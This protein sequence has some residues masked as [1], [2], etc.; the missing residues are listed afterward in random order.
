MFVKKPK[1]PREVLEEREKALVR[2]YFEQRPCGVV[3]DVG[4]NEPVSAFSQSWHLEEKLG[5]KAVLVEPNPVLAAR[6]RSARPNALTFECACCATEADLT[7]YIPVKEDGGEI[8]SH[9]AIGKNLDSHSYAK[10][11]EVTVRGRPLDHLLE[12]AGV[13]SID[14]L[15]IDVEGAELEV[16]KGFDIGKYRP[17]LILLE[18]KHL[19]LNK[20]RYLTRHGYRLCKRTGLNCW[21]VPQ[22]AR[23]PPQS[24]REKARIF[25]R[26]YLS[27]WWKKLRYALRTER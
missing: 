26:L 8:H 27:I 11:R 16:L 2:E 20:H 19:Y 18:D 10:F 13:Q 22:D 14:L 6:A 5:W 15:S 24:L 23:R 4:A 9:A 17:G 21:Y 1:P 12:E 25:K 7:L 3:V